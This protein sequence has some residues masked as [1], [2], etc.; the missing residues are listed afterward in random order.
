MPRKQ[1]LLSNNL[2]GYK[3]LMTPIYEQQRITQD[4]MV[5]LPCRATHKI[6]ARSVKI[7]EEDNLYAIFASYVNKPVSFMRQ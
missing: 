5:G 6:K 1:G 2:Y 4:E 7:R 3:V